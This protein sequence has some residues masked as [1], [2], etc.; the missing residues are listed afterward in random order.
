LLKTYRSV[1]SKGA[2][3]GGVILGIVMAIPFLLS[4]YLL[5]QGP[6]AAIFSLSLLSLLFFV[7]AFMGYMIYSGV[8]MK[9][10]IGEEEL[11][12]QIGFHKRKIPYSL[13]KEIRLENLSLIRLRMFGASWPGFVWG[14]FS[15]AGVGTVHLYCTKWRGDF[16]LVELRDGKKLGIT[17]EKQT[18]FIEEVKRRVK[19]FAEVKIEKP[20]KLAHNRLVYSQV[21]LVITAYIALIAYVFYVY[22]ALPAVIPVHFGLNGNPN[23][24]AP[25]SE[26]LSILLIAAIF[27]ALNTL[28][29]LKF[30]K[31]EKIVTLF[32]GIMF[33]LTI[34]IFFGIIEWIVTASTSI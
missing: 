21:I 17:P 2:T 19:E 7:L 33:I 16:T 22:P 10:V 1:P 24:W 15:V 12:F 31:H 29:T 14:F 25:K 13:I 8:N 6:G 5:S 9:Y 20:I 34:A 18:Q 4:V 3:M 26:L 28:L 23:R 27:P 30:G 32:L 11:T